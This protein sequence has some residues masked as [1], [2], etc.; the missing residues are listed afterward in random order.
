M[1]AAPSLALLLASYGAASGLISPAGAMSATGFSLSMDDWIHTRHAA[2]MRAL[3]RRGVGETAAWYA[4]V[5]LVAQWAHETG[6]GRAEWDYALGNIRANPGW[7]GLIHY[8]DD[9]GGLYAPRPYRAYATLDEG[10]EDAVR[11]V[12]DAPMYR[13]SF[14]ALIASSIDGPFTVQADNRSVRLPMDAV[15]WYA[16]ITRA[17]WHPFSDRSQYIFQSTLTRTAQTV[18]DAPPESNAAPVI[19]AALGAVLAA[20]GLWW[21]RR[22][23]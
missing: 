23:H 7:T 9:S 17:G 2:A 4:A 5:A 3:L 20:A 18:G 11:L 13:P 21:W 8:L 15:Q 12:V 6:W 22:S 19:G 1:T 16:D 14:L 10:A